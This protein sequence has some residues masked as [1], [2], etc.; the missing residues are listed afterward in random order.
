M[1]AVL[2][3]ERQSSNGTFAE[4]FSFNAVNPQC[5]EESKR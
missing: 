4:R 5:E 3:S 1:A 2:E